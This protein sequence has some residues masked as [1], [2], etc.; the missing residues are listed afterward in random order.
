M[1][2]DMNQC[3]RCQVMVRDPSEVCPLCHNVLTLQGDE[4]EQSYPSVYGKIQ[5]KKRL[6]SLLV[7]FLAILGVALCVINYYVNGGFG[8]SYLTSI[9]ILY[10]L[11][12]IFYG[13][14]RKTNHIRKIFVQG[15]ATMIYLGVLDAFTGG[16]GWSVNYGLPA[17]LLVLDGVLVVCM[18]VN[19]RNW[20]NYLLVQL[21]A[22]L[23]GLVLLVLYL[24]GVAGNAVLV[25]CNLGASAMIFSFCL[26]MGNR[27]AKQEL[28]KRFY[29]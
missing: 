17:L 26:S 23:A 2:K 11:Y 12:T 22:L 1:R 19:F 8:W 27:K 15:A 25:W 7:Y 3:K 13:F 10:L 4:Q 21:F 18:L 16:E 29:V 28:K 5:W 24:C 6:F 14:Y 9:T 20:Q